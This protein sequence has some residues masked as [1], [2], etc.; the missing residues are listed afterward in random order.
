MARFVL[1]KHSGLLRPTR[2]TFQLI[3]DNN[4]PVL[5][6]EPYNTKGAALEGI[7]TVRRLAPTADSDTREDYA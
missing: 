3:A 7:A 6:S 4:E 5:T 2:Y 1:R